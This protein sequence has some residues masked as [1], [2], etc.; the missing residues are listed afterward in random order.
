VCV[1]LYG[2]C[3][4][5]SRIRP[6]CQAHGIPLVQDAAE[7]LGAVFEQRSEVGGQKSEGDRSGMS[8]TMAAGV[9]LA[10]GGRAVGASGQGEPAGCQGDIAVFSFN[11]NKIITTSGGGMLVSA[12]K[13]WVDR[14]RHWATQARD[15]APHY[16][17]SEIG[18][19]Y[20]MS[21]LLAAVG[22][23][24]LRSLDKK[25]ARRR[26]IFELYQQVLS[27]PPP[28]PRPLTSDL[29]PLTSDLRPLTSDLCPPPASASCPSPPG[30]G[31][32][33]G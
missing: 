2:Q 7:A 6:I 26:A 15:P 25:I 33:I 10:V 13:D 32:I 30:A 29:R 8:S 9:P 1:D 16:E 17:H 22:R 21:N 20:R 27:C 12:R 23:G 28:T 4:D 18:H 3:A 24:Q 19:N 5:Y 14:V 31:R 11:G